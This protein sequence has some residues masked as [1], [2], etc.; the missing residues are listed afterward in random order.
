[1]IADI[2]HFKNVNDSHGHDAGDTV[3]QDFAIRMRRHTRGI[4]LACRLWG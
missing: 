2:D 1:M 3:L 4:D